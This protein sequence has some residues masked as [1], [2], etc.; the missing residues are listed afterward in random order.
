M[1][2]AA[3]GVQGQ[4]GAAFLIYGGQTLEAVTTLFEMPSCESLQGWQI[5]GDVEFGRLGAALSGGGDLNA[6]L[7]ADGGIGAPGDPSDGAPAGG[8]AY[9]IFGRGQQSN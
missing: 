9:L 7:F 3:P 8:T 4:L 6:D 5:T 1:I 2:V